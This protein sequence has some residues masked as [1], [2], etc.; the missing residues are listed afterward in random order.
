MNCKFVFEKVIY[1]LYANKVTYYRNQVNR[2]IGL[3]R[4]KTPGIED[5]SLH[6]YVYVVIF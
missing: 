2:N 4:T 5:N 1:Y 3:L 6:Y